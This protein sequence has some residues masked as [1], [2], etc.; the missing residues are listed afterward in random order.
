MGGNCY[1]FGT[2]DGTPWQCHGGCYGGYYGAGSPAG[3][4]LSGGW[5]YGP[6]SIYSDPYAVYGVVN[7]PPIP[8][9]EPTKPM[10]KPT[11]P[12]PKSGMGANLKF[13]LPAD[14]RLYV[15]GR[16]TLLT[17]T[18]RAFTTPPLVAGQKFYYDVRA[19]LMVDGKPVVEER[20]VIVESG[21][22]LTESFTKLLA[23]AEGKGV[24]IAE[25]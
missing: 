23:V 21:A 19:E 7:Q 15:D 14:A 4:G 22:D 9:T 18:E 11:A 5:G 13:R 1:G 10:D 8:V 25:K 20:R 17:G 6:R 12:P 24:P 2:L 16:L 3:P